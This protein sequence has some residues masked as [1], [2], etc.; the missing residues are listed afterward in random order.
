MCY[1]RKKNLQLYFFTIFIIL[2]NPIEK[3]SVQKE[4]LAFS[5]HV[6]IPHTKRYAYMKKYKNVF[7]YEKK[8]MFS[9]E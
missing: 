4:L 2:F 3:L 9:S 8:M 5:F 1:I 7:S 6:Q